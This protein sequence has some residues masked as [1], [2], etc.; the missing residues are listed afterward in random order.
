M[1]TVVITGSTRGIGYGLADSFLAL[2]CQVV[3][4]GRSQ[5]G[6]DRAVSEL[7]GR[8]GSERVLGF[9]GDVISYENMQGLWDTART[10]FGKIDIWI[11]NAGIANPLAKFWEQPPDL[12][13]KVIETNLLG[14]MYGTSVAM[15]GML[16]QGGG[17]VYNLEG[18]GSNGGSR[19][20]EGLEL[21]GSTKAGLRF[22]DDALFREAE[23][24]TVITGAIQP[25]MVATQMLSSQYEGKPQDWERARR[26]FNIIANRVETVTPVLAQKILEN[27]KNGARI[28]FTSRGQIL[29]RFLTAPFVKRKVFD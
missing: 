20:V 3:V 17:A 11:N 6:V 27:T 12:I 4:N 8:Y 18:Y 10:H 24:T 7:A 13:K 16:Q 2:S 21:Y 14:A 9:T 26:I 1:K 19:M 28:S 5:A 22:F 25:G 29:L 23:G 15:K